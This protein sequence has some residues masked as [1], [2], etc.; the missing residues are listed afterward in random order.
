MARIRTIKPGFFKHSAL[1]DAEKETGLPLRLGYAGLW[2]CCDREGRFKWRPREL[3]LDALPFDDCD[4]SRVLDALASRGFLV[5]YESAGEVYGHIPTWRKH[6][7]INNREAASEIPEPPSIQSIDAS[8]TRHC[9]VDHASDTRLEGK[10]IGEGDKG[11]EGDARERAGQSIPDSADARILCETV[12]IFPVRQQEEI[13]RLMLT[14]A[15]ATSRSGSECIAH[16]AAR[17]AEYQVEGP[18][19]E[20]QY[21]SAHKF[22]MSGKWD[23]PD[24][25]PRAKVGGSKSQEKERWEQFKA[26]EVDTDDEKGNV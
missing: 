2:V 9:R 26:D 17:W 5:K 19:L 10:E 4:F 15:K 25:W 6:Q 22:F 16:M 20:W 8:I 23:T 21:G 3:K 13:H 1:F 24:T 11:R 14:H 7:F 18:S 12:G